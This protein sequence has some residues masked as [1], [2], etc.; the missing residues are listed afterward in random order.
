MWFYTHIPIKLLASV[1]AFDSPHCF[2][3]SSVL[4]TCAYYINIILL[5]KSAF[6]KTTE[7]QE[8]VTLAQFLGM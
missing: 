5:N 4:V 6:P 1:F 3:I 7:L 2:Y 8:S